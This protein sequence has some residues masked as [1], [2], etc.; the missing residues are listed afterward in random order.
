MANTR[1]TIRVFSNRDVGIDLLKT[2]SSFLVV[3]IHCY[4]HFAQMNL[5]IANCL[6]SL[7]HLG[8]GCFFIITG[9]YFPIMVSKE[10]MRGYLSRTIKLALWAMAIYLVFNILYYQLVWKDFMIPITDIIG[11]SSLLNLIIYNDTGISLHLWYL[12]ALIYTILFILLFYRF[13]KTTALYIIA[14]IFLA[15]GIV[16]CYMNF[17]IIVFRNWIFYGVPFVSIGI[18]IR[19]HKKSLSKSGSYIVL[20]LLC[21]SVVS[22]VVESY[23]LGVTRALYPFSIL[24]VSCMLVLAISFDKKLMN[25]LSQYN[26][27]PYVYY[28][29]RLSMYIYIF[30]IAV[31]RVLDLCL[32]H[33][34]PETVQF[35]VL[36]PFIIYFLSIG[37]SLVWLKIPYR[38][39]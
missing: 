32:Q 30:H 37:L 28:G 19:E 1:Q 33:Q 16:L 35:G 20:A 14:F 39:F 2:L 34:T 38:P 5:N 36:Y 21:I 27:L 7:A 12:F 3:V 15:C 29:A 25:S 4:G 22:I 8:V 18:F 13:N 10:K 26:I 6:N 11:K 31:K 17:P 23:M 24:A 9:Y